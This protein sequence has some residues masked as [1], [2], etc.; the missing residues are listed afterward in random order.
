[1]AV[2]LAM[3][4]RNP[5]TGA[6]SYNYYQMLHTAGRAACLVRDQVRESRP[7]GAFYVTGADLDA[8]QVAEESLSAAP[9]LAANGFYPAPDLGERWFRWQE[10][11][12]APPEPEPVA[13][14]AAPV[15]EAPVVVEAPAPAPKPKK[16]RAK[17]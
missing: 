3:G 7:G 13:E 14:V 17:F 8:L 16:A 15:E 5:Y 12:P 1:M 2:R 6:A 11:A 10:A 4:T 9:I